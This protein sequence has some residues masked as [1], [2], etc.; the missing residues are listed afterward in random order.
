[1]PRK[2]ADLVQA[3]AAET[4][5]DPQDHFLVGHEL[6][7]QGELELANQEFRRALQLNAK[8]F[9]THYF[10]GICCVTSGKPEVAVAHLSDLPEPAAELIWIYLLRG[11]ALGQMEDYAAA[12]T[13]FDRALALEPSPATLYVL[14]NNRGVMRVSQKETWAKG[15]EDLKKAAALRPDQYQAQVSLAEAYRLDGRLD[16]AGQNLDEAIALASRQVQAGELKPATLALLHHS[17]ARLQ[18]QRLQ[19]EPAL[20]S[21]AEAVRLAGD[22]RAPAQPRRTSTGA[23]FCTWNRDMPRRWPHTTRLWRLIR[24]VWMSIVG[25]A[26]FC[27]FSASTP[28]LRQRSIP[29]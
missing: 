1:M 20:R 28:M 7:S 22:D 6:Y 10:L 25:A 8:H 24:N 3:L 16:E 18:L 27:W 13:D 11:F 17:R 23:A 14:Y 15:V 26:W 9:W 4:D 2:K 19:R 21:L 29:T 12:E 5:L